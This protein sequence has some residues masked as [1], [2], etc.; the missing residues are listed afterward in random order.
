[1]WTPRKIGQMPQ[2]SQEKNCG[3][4][5]EG[6]GGGMIYDVICRFLQMH[7]GFLIANMTTGIIRTILFLA[8]VR[9]FELKLLLE[10]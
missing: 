7:N 1:M 4:N 9:E 5:F 10:Y 8:L 3:T 6:H 2:L